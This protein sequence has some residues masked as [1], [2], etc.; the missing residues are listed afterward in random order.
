MKVVL[1]GAH[2]S[3]NLGGPSLLAGTCRVLA[4]A[5]GPVECSLFSLFAADDQARGKQRNVAILPYRKKD[6]Y[7][8][9]VLAALVGALRKVGVKVR[10]SFR[11]PVLGPIAQADWVA[12]INGIMLTDLF[13]SARGLLEQAMQLLIPVWLGKPMVKF[14]QDMGPFQVPLNRWV[15]KF[16]LPR[17]ALVLVRSEASRQNLEAIGIRENVRVRPDTAFLLEPADPA[18]IAQILAAEGLVRRPRVA[19]V[20]SRQVDRR[21]RQ[22]EGTAPEAPNSYVR[23]LAAAADHLVETQGAEV[24]FIPNELAREPGGYDDESVSR[25]IAAEMKRAGAARI[26]SRGYDAGELKGVIG[27]CDLVVTSRYHSTV[28]ALSQGVPTLVV[29]WGYKYGELMGLA[30]QERHVF[31]FAR[32]RAGEIVERIDAMWG[33]LDAIR[34]AIE[35]C[36]PRIRSAVLAGGQWVREAVGLEPMA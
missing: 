7:Q 17:L 25:K 8:A 14:T 34:A 20:A 28:A 6:L 12:D 35:P 36:I 30:G 29:G 31:D 1:W 26:L 27:T 9:F 22:M 24:V 21:I 33:E 13:P 15:A 19:L 3:R 2:L 4:E 16:C 18:R 10:R 5:F 11:N 32:A 23:L